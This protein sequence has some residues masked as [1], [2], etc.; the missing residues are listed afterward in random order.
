MRDLKLDLSNELVIVD[1]SPAEL[2][3]AEQSAQHI[4]TEYET[5]IGSHSIS[6]TYGI[7]F[8]DVI[9]VKNPNL[10]AINSILRGKLQSRDDIERIERFEVLF[11]PQTRLLEVLF[12]AQST[13]GLVVASMEI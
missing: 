4:A 1:G 2:A 12:E 3:G 10:G 7:P 6:T 5:P 8:F 9:F 11:N 13:E